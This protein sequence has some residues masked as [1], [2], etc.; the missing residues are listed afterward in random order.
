MSSMAATS[1][2]SDL[3]RGV[4]EDLSVPSEE[5]PVN[6]E[7]EEPVTQEESVPISSSSLEIPEVDVP[8]TVETQPEPHLTNSISEDY[9]S[10]LEAEERHVLLSPENL[11]VD[12]VEL[13]DDSIPLADAEPGLEVVANVEAP[14]LGTL[15]LPSQAQRSVEE[16]TE[17]SFTSNTGS[18]VDCNKIIKEGH[19][20][21]PA[22]ETEC[23]VPNEGQF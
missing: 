16:T 17:V 19:V 15:E 7:P 1:V 5:L 2:E 10:T 14:V 8:V 6:P 20:I 18:L 12:N 4:A 23:I 13:N 11:E 21:E 3:R 22:S 9:V